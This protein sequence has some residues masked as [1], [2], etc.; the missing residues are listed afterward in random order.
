MIITELSVFAAVP[1]VAQEQVVVTAANYV[2]AETDTQM[3]GY[4]E[5]YG[6]FR[7]FHHSQDPYDAENRDTFGAMTEYR[8][9]PMRR[10][11]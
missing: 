1:V 2:R 4:I 9:E 7:R 6:S 8:V 3:K 11:R 10:L 5:I